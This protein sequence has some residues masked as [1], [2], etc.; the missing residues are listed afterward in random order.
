MQRLRTNLIGVDQGENI[1]FSDYA[2]GGE[3]WT[4]Q[5]ARERRHSVTF[6]QPFHSVPVVHCSLSMWDVDHARNTRADITAENISRTGFDVVFR[7]W[8]DTR[9]A[10]ARARWLAIGELPDEDDWQL[11]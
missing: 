7:T 8:G 6:R 10:R 1:L 2:D 4:S 3:M 11:Y 5:G 9:V